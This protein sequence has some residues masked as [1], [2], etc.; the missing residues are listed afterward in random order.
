MNMH[1]SYRA[2]LSMT[3]SEKRT[4]KEEDEKSRVNR[5]E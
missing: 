5:R 1:D 3:D 4:K 2:R